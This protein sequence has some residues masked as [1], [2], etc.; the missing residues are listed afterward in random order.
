MEFI[1]DAVFPAHPGAAHGAAALWDTFHG[2]AH[3]GVRCHAG[4]VAGPAEPLGADE[5]SDEGEAGQVS[6]LTIV[7]SSPF[8]RFL[9][10]DSP[11]DPAKEAVLEH[12][13]TPLLL[14]GER[15]RFTRIGDD[16][17][18]DRGVQLQF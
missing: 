11:I 4:H 18:D 15:P 13:E 14:L 7:S 1:L 5:A 12:E 6:K 17:P 16:W 2:T 10:P 9:I 3:H 8:S